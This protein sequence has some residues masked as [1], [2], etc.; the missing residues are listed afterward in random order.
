MGRARSRLEAVLLEFLVQRGL[1]TDDTIAVAY[2]GGSDSTALL[3]ALAALEWRKPIAVH[4]DHGIRCPEEV[5][6]ERNLVAEICAAI[7]AKLIIAHVRPGAVLERAKATGDGVEAE[8]RR[9]RYAALRAVMR[10][11]GA[12][13]ALFAHTRDDQIETL[14][15]RLFGGSGTGGLGGIPMVTGQFMRPFLEIEKSTLL[16]YLEDRGLAFSTDS[17]NGSDDYLRNRIRR[18]LVPA[19]DSSFPGWRTG[20]TTTAAKARRDEEALSVAADAITFCPS[21]AAASEV[22]VS[23]ALL[24]AA[25]R[26]I[27]IK[28]IVR[29]GG[30]MLGKERFSS[31]M[32]ATALKALLCGSG[33]RGAGLELRIMKGRVIL[34]RG[35]DFPRLG[36]YFVLIDRPRRVRVGT[37]EVRAAWASGARVGIRADAFRFPLVVRSRRP[38]DVI[39]L[40]DGTKRLDALFS[41]WALTE[42][43]R[44]AAPIVEDRDGIVAVLGAEFGGK[45]RYRERP[46]GDS[47]RSLI[48]IVKG[49]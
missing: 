18:Y 49:V 38:G 28:A 19:L 5:A 8:A 10:R 20:L 36:G 25:P 41:E 32:A 16:S 4:V 47:S 48:V 26:A 31:R 21:N 35:L 24:L 17:T 33:Y 23:S 34:R 15:M 37:I 11:T 39:A 44:G 27:A 45:D 6:A 13:A 30:K 42:I 3:V 40:K 22:W 1:S 9:F 2:S 12:K 46:S 29:A 43:A 7:G 14:L